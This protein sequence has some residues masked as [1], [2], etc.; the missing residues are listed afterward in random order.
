MTS[1]PSELL[2]DPLFQLNAVLWL[3]QPLPDGDEIIP[4]LYA[5]G[6]TVYAIAP[7]L[8]PPPDLRL[9]AQ[10]AQINMQDMVRPDVVLTHESGRK[11]AF[12]ECKASSSALTSSTAQARSLLVVTG[13]RAAEVLGLASGQVS[14]SLLGLVIPESDREPV[15]QTLASLSK[16]LD[17]NRLLAGQFSV[18]GFVLTDTD[19]SIVINGLGSAFF[20]LPSGANPFMK[21]EPD[22]DPRPLYFIPYDPDVV[23][24]EQE[25][26]SCK[27]MLFERMHS[28]ITAAIGRANPPIESV[29]ESQ[30]ILNDA[31]FGMYGHW[32]NRE[33]ARHMRRLCREFMDA[34]TQAVNA[35]VLGTM[36]FQPGEGWK[37]SLQN[38]EQHERVIDALT[39]FSCEMLDLRTEPQPSFFDDLEDN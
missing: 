34:L 31:M 11:F 36:V 15:A 18:L 37:I 9:A 12:T 1:I 19:I 4:L 14:A 24:S 21:R 29:L 30:K 3:T 6:F 25:K 20:A 28:T 39:R 32:E 26:V 35:V 22:T 10:Q 16:E 2:K 13:P 5:R 17:E 38:E 33:S 7:L 27:R 23:Q 8:G